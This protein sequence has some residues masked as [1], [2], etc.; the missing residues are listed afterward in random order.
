MRLS[1]YRRIA[2]KP[3]IDAR[4]RINLLMTIDPP[5]D[6]ICGIWQVDQSALTC[7]KERYARL[8]IPVDIPD[9]YVLRATV[10]RIFGVDTLAF[11]LV[12]DGRQVL[13]AMDGY[14]GDVA[15]LG[16][17]DG[18]KQNN[19]ETTMRTTV[20]PE[21]RAVQIEIRVTPRSVSLVADGKRIVQWQG[22][23]A[24]FSMQEEWQVPRKDWLH[25]ACYEAGFEIS[26]LWLEASQP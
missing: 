2:A 3:V 25:L 15:G 8:Q 5:R 14:G 22:D 6:A 11:V 21:N 7:H 16:L 17:V 26:S 12:V 23:A 4:G 10:K 24:A 1:P 9:S 20:F 19:N 18:K 13:L